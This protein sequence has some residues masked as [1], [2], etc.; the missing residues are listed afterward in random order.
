MKVAIY[1]IIGNKKGQ[2]TEEQLDQLR[3]LALSKHREVYLFVDRQSGKTSERVEF[4]KLFESAARR[5]F[6][7]VLVWALDRFVGENVVETFLNIRKLSRYG[8][9]FM[10]GTEPHF[11]TAGPAGELMIPIA[12]W[13]AQQERTPH[14]GAH[15]SGPGDGALAG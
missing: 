12:V 4:Q 9:Q 7:G 1:S 10:S 14:F 13:I 11:C 8:V 15:Q 6:E 3:R 2:D 5:E